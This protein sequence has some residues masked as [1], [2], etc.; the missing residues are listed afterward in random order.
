MLFYLMVSYISYYYICHICPIPPIPTYVIILLHPEIAT[1]YCMHP[2]TY[3]VFYINPGPL[4]MY[5]LTAHRK[6]NPRLI[7]TTSEKVCMRV[8]LNVDGARACSVRCAPIYLSSYQSKQ[9]A[10]RRPVACACLVGRGDIAAMRMRAIQQHIHTY[11]Y[12]LHVW[13]HD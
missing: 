12:M 6:S 13:P 10:L 1:T 7:T 5:T 2:I 11:I 4:A 8:W 9:R 3:D